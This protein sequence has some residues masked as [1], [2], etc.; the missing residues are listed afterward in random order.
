[1]SVDILK[2]VEKL[3]VTVGFTMSSDIIWTFLESHITSR[4]IQ[5]TLASGLTIPIIKSIREIGSNSC[6]VTSQNFGCFCREENFV[7]VWE[8]S[9]EALLSHAAE[10]E[11][12]LIQQMFD[13]P[14]AAQATSM[15]RPRASRYAS[16]YVQKND[17]TGT[18]PMAPAVL[19]KLDR[20]Q[21]AIDQ[22]DS[23][24][25]VYDPEK[26]KDNDL[27]RPFLLG[28]GIMISLAIILVI[29]V[30]MACVAKVWSRPNPI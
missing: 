13:A 29:V 4:Q 10:L 25:K 6:S 27:E 3:G 26:A 8:D 11:Q 7:L 18:L 19:E 21:A 20:I 22:E 16:L 2:V 17:S 23:A 1:L 24:G 14:D 30:E 28:H 15:P 12:T 5:L 9:M